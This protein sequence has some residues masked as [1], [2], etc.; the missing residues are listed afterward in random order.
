MIYLVLSL[1]L[2]DKSKPFKQNRC[3]M[4]YIPKIMGCQFVT[5][6]TEG[7][8]KGNYTQLAVQVILF[9]VLQKFG[10]CQEE[11]G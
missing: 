1:D 8:E 5:R 4:Q 11:Q 2:G 10:I 7:K 9:R 3:Q 6:A